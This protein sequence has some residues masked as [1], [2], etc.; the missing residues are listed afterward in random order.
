MPLP[1]FERLPAERRSAIL[2]V[3]QRHLAREGRSGASY[4]QIIAEAGLSKTSAYLYF[5]GREDLVR[6]VVARVVARLEAALGRW[7]PVDSAR[8]FWA[9]LEAQS[10][11]LR[12]HLA[13]NAEELAIV[14]ALEP[15][16]WPQAQAWLD[17]MLENGRAVGVIRTDV[18]PLVMAQVT[19]AVLSTLDGLAVEALQAGHAVD[20]A[21][22][23]TL[24]EGLWSRR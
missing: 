15:N 20:E 10:A 6:A 12:A 19:R 1:R 22:G 7:A 2:A 11:A 14:A 21:Q 3:A 24:L 16:E 5:D 17:A 4:N 8:A 18:A 13:S 9:Q 23:R